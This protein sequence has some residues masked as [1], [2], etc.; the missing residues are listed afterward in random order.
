MKVAI[1]GAFSYSGKYISRRLLERGEEVITLTGHPN[2]PDPFDD[3]VIAYDKVD[4]FVYNPIDDIRSAFGHLKHKFRWDI[5]VYE[6]N[7]RAFCC[8][9]FKTHLLQL[10]RKFNSFFLVAVFDAEQHITA[11]RQAVSGGYLR[12]GESDTKI[13]RYTHDFAG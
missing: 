5:F 8:D 6:F 10:T 4:F 9:N 12:L 2:R 11:H 1:T 7:A 13:V 3:R